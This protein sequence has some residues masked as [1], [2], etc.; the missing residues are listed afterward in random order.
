MSDNVFS[1]LRA[2]LGSDLVA[3]DLSGRTRVAVDSA[4]AAAQVCS[5]ASEAG[6]KVRLAGRGTWLPDDAPADLTL[7]S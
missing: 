3:R 4:D 1:L 7:T 5:M 6:W 2:R